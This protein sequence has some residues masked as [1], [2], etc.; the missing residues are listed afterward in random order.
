MTAESNI[1]SD[2]DETKKRSMLKS[3]FGSKKK[4]GVLEEAKMRDK[5]KMKNA[6]QWVD[7]QEQ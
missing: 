7:K 6:S 2:R 3:L 5:K 4:P 1:L